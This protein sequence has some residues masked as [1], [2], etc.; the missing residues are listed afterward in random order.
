MFF[1]FFLNLR[2]PAV[3][4]RFN[5]LSRNQGLSGATVPKLKIATKRFSATRNGWPRLANDYRSDGFGCEVGGNSI[6]GRD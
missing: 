1:S 2:E 4:R 5:G 6:A 3:S